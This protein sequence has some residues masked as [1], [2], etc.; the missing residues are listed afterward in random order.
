M[1]LLFTVDRAYRPVLDTCLRSILRFPRDGGY[2]IYIMHSDLGPED[3]AALEA[4]CAEKN[5][6]LR[7]VDTDGAMVEDFPVTDRYPRQMYYRLLAAR[8]LPDTLDRVLYLDP[9]IVVINS[10]E[11]LWRVDLGGA[12]FG[13]CTHVREFLTRVNQFRLG[14]EEGCP[15]LNSGVLLMDLAALRREQDPEEIRAYVERFGDRLTLPDQDIL[16]AL[17]GKRTKLL[18]TMRYN[19]SDRVLAAY[20][21]SPR[22]QGPMLDVDWVRENAA[23]IH[24]CGRNKPWKDNYI[25][26]LDVFYREVLDGKG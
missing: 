10:L 12:L 25:G 4:V 17:Y 19:L 7:L 1:E 5:A 14:A 11:P 13:A 18:D 22:R 6:S 9:D 24:Y 21:M 26:V 20:N 16:S 3:R 8:F 15:Y 2:R 23:I